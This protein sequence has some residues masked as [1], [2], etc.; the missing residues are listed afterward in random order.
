[1]LDTDT[2]F[3][4]VDR[5]ADVAAEDLPRLRPG[6][7][8]DATDGPA[9]V[10]RDADGTEVTRYDWPDLRFSISWKAYCFTNEHE[11]M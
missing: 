7:T 2:V 5:V 11:R 9:W 8:L 10:V 1:M 3:H 4:G 6:M